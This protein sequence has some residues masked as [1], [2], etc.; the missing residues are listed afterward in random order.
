MGR[1]HNMHPFMSL[2]IFM[3]YV[4]HVLVEGKKKLWPEPK[5]KYYSSLDSN[6][7]I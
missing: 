4:F 2:C 3:Q 5:I 6:K 7:I 1:I